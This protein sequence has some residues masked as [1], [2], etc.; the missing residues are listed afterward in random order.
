MKNKNEV[1]SAIDETMI[2]LREKYKE[3]FI[4]EDY[5]L[6]DYGSESDILRFYTN[7]MNPENEYGFVVLYND[8]SGKREY[9]DN[10]FGYLIRNQMEDYITN[11]IQNEFTDVK[12]YLQHEEDTFDNRLNS[13]S[14][15]DDLFSIMP[16]YT[17]ALNVY[18]CG[19]KN[20]DKLDYQEA[21]A[22]IENL[23]LESKH[24]YSI[25][26][27][28]VSDDVYNSIH[29]YEQDDFRSF[30]ASH[31]NPDGEKYYARYNEYISDGYIE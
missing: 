4:F 2:I 23:L 27:F 10:Y 29:R 20:T 6:A 9:E 28:V 21:F 13:N 17:I 7:K 11:I 8:E 22:R 12:V 15:L 14:N 25:T 1:L 31:R 30:Y 3:E 26:I 24:T 19:N 5:E 18:V 16:D